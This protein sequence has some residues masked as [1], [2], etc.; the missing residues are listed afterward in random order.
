MSNRKQTKADL[1]AQLSKALDELIAVKEDR[2]KMKEMLNYSRDV[3][4]R[5]RGAI[6]YIILEARRKN[7]ADLFGNSFARKV[8]KEEML[9]KA[10]DEL[11]GLAARLA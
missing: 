6:T 3:A 1:E 4:F 11:S 9:L 7:G 2:N 10:E 5:A 8:A